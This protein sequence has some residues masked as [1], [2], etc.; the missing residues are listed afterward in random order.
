M[1]R[2]EVVWLSS[3]RG[4]RGREQSGPR[5][6]VIL[7]SADLMG[8]STVVVAPT[9]TRAAPASFRPEVT[10]EGAR[11][12]VLVDQITAMDWSRIGESIRVLSWDEF[13]SV[14]RALKFV[15]G[16]AT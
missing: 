13:V 1:R 6:G 12:R 3:I 5:Y 2:G 16:L 8:L 15:L 10:I 7:Q 11:T 14:D 9:S 4:A